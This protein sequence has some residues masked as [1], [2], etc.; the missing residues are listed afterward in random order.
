MLAA[1]GDLC[2][3][4]GLARVQKCLGTRELGPCKSWSFEAHATFD[5]HNH[6]ALTV[7]QHD[8]ARPCYTPFVDMQGDELSLPISIAVCFVPLLPPQFEHNL[9]TIRTW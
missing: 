6:E 8:A 2:L 7:G 1:G 5:K 9:P 4:L 3:A